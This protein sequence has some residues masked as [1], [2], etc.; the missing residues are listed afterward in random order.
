MSRTPPTRGIPLPIHRHE[1][2]ATGRCV[3]MLVG[4]GRCH[5]ERCAVRDCDTRREPH[6][7][8]CLTHRTTMLTT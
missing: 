7:R 8:V 5:A 3:V 6:L 4:A 1:W 2:D